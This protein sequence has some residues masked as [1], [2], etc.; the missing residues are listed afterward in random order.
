MT[1]LDLYG[2]MVRCSTRASTVVPTIS[3][4]FLLGYN[5]GVANADFCW[6]G[7]TD[8]WDNGV[9]FMDSHEWL[10]FF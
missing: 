5:C 8:P 10:D 1:A 6:S 3:L 4:R 2:F 9:V 7:F